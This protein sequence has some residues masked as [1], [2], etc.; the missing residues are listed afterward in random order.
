MSADY[1]VQPRFDFLLK[2]EVSLAWYVGADSVKL[3][4]GIV[5]LKMTKRILPHVVNNS[6]KM[7]LINAS[8]LSRSSAKTS[9]MMHN[10]MRDVHVTATP[11]IH[12]DKLAICLLVSSPTES[13]GHNSIT[14]ITSSTRSFL[15]RRTNVASF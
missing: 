12:F 5:I 10:R 2:R 9:K 13:K 15:S 7:D 11:F 1:N 4:R 14:F 8:P 3:T 6:S